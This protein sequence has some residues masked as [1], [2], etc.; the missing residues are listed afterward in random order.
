M[1]MRVKNL[2]EKDVYIT[3]SST[4]RSRKSKHKKISQP[5]RPHWVCCTLFASFLRTVSTISHG[6]GYRVA[7]PKREAMREPRTWDRRVEHPRL[8]FTL[9]TN[10]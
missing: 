9:I 5:K 8:S 6:V 2:L 4:V 3:L 10:R 1:G 7:Y